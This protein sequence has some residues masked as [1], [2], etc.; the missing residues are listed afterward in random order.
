VQRGN[1]DVQT[2]NELAGMICSHF[3]PRGVIM[4]PCEGDGNFSCW[5][6][7]MSDRFVRMEIKKGFDFYDYAGGR[8]DWI[9]TNPPWSKVRKFLIHSMAATD[10]IVF[11][12]TVNHVFT[13]ARIRDAD[14]YG[15]GLKEILM[16]DTPSKADGWPQSSFQLGAVHWKRGY[17][18]PVTIGRGK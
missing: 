18:G 1:D 2:P 4:E 15:F 16:V 9:V 8:V 5:L 6:E 14:V 10:N 17:A 7:P 12:I 11:L 13:K 3:G